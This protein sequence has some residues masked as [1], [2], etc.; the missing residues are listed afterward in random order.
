MNGNTT[1]QGKVND[2]LD[3]EKITKILLREIKERENQP[4][5]TE[6]KKLIKSRVLG[7]EFNENQ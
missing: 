7:E 2:E 3:L 5:K 6:L 1:N 4:N